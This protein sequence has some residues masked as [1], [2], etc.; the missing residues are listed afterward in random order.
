MSDLRLVIFDV[1]GTLVD[2]Q[3]SIVQSMTAAFAA[4]DRDTPDRST[5]LSIVGLSLPEAFAVLAPWADAQENA[6]LVQAYKD[7]YSASRAGGTEGSVLYPGA[8]DTLSA[9][10]GID[11]LLLGIATGK[12]RRGLDILFDTHGFEGLFQTVQVS[13]FHPSKPHPSMIL[14]AMSEVGV[15][16]DQTVMIGDAT[17]DMDM[18]RAARC[19]GIGVDWGYHRPEDLLSAGAAEIV[20]SFARLTEILTDQWVIA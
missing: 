10:A 16:P 12:S 3:N 11:H 6:R 14:Q 19:A 17:F 7:A 1:D 13:D 4:L 2:S 20:D 8:M 15:T 9:L 5:L 18:A